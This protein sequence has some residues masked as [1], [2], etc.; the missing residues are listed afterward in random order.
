MKSKKKTKKKLKGGD[1]TK[2]GLLEAFIHR[3]FSKPDNFAD[4]IESGRYDIVVALLVIALFYFIF[5]VT[6]ELL[7]SNN[8][9]RRGNKK[10]SSAPKQQEVCT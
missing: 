2:K 3:Y 1:A 7:P 8:K 10:R 9:Q 5:K 6:Q 4:E